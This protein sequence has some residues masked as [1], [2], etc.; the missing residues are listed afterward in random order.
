[1]C[2]YCVDLTVCSWVIIPFIPRIVHG[3]VYL[4]FCLLSDLS[5]LSVLLVLFVST[6]SHFWIFSPPTIPF[7]FCFLSSYHQPHNAVLLGKTISYGKR[8][9]R[10]YV[11]LTTTSVFLTVSTGISE[12]FFMLHALVVI[13][14]WVTRVS[15]VSTYR[16]TNCV[17]W[18]NVMNCRDEF[19]RCQSLIQALKSQMTVCP[20]GTT[21]NSALQ[22]YFEI[23]HTPAHIL[24]T[25]TVQYSTTCFGLP[26]RYIDARV[27][28]VCLVTQV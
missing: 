21:A 8:T 26:I 14:V 3:F 5:L 9:N 12:A 1:M 17:A 23:F 11:M 15:S 25:G 7:V 16:A 10:M 2:R 20:I 13:K 28:L 18:N 27:N 6:P 24:P 22:R 19:V 4:L